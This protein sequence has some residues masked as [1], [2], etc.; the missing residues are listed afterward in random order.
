MW[1]WQ[2]VKEFKKSDDKEWLVVEKLK[3]F[4]A[5]FRREIA[6]LFKDPITSPFKKSPKKVTA[7]STT[8]V[9]PSREQQLERQLVEE[10][11]LWQTEKASLETY[12]KELER[13]IKT[14]KDLETTRSDLSFEELKHIQLIASQTNSSEQRARVAYFTHNKDIVNAIMSIVTED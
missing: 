12:I 14:Y 1:L 11:Q 2:F 7:T 9:T 10:R 3:E 13:Q 4:A 8:T 6:E 5:D